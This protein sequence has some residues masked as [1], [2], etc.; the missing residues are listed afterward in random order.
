MVVRYK[1][2]DE[3]GMTYGQTQWGEGATYSTSGRGGLCGSGW[4]HCYNDPLVA[5]LMNPYHADFTH[6]KICKVECYG[7]N[8]LDHGLKEGWTSMAFLEWI[9]VP[10]ISTNQRIA[11]G[12]LCAKRVCTD[13][14]WLTWTDGWLSGADRSYVAAA[15]AAYSAY[16]YAAARDSA[17]AAIASAAYAAAAV[18]AYNAARAAAGAAVHAAYAATTIDLPALAQEAMQY[19]PR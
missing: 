7:Q 3:N 1:L 6:P 5:L 19:V 14:K 16:A 4:L 10:E 18:A 11:F 2:T 17:Y 15:D 12:L 9:D 13:Q 8:K